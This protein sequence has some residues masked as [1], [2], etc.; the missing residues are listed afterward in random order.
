MVPNCQSEALVDFGIGLPGGNLPD[1][2]DGPSYTVV[3]LGIRL[4]AQETDFYLE[5]SHKRKCYAKRK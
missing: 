1:F 5:I 4:C 2:K 3:S